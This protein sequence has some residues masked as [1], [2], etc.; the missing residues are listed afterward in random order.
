EPDACCAVPGAKEVLTGTGGKDKEWQMPK[1][2]NPRG[3]T[4]RPTDAPGDDHPNPYIVKK[5]KQNAPN[6]EPVMVHPKQVKEAM[7]KLAKAKA[8][9]GRPPNFLVFLLDDVGWLDP[10]FNGGGCTVGNP[11][12]HMDKVAHQ[13]LVLTSAYS[14]PSCSPSRASI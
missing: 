1:P 14:T 6:M 4:T 13:G 10:G 12:P 9:H 2:G 8:K 3:A 5:T 7:E 11:T